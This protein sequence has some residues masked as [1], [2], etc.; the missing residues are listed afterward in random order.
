MNVDTE[1]QSQTRLHSLV[2]V[3]PATIAILAAIS[4]GASV[5]V[6]QLQ[7]V[8][9]PSPF[10]VAGSP[11]IAIWELDQAADYSFDDAKIEIASGRGQLKANPQW[12]DASYDYRVPLTVTAGAGGASVGQ[13]VSITA[14]TN[15]YVSLGIL[16]ADRDD[17]RIV[18]WNGAANIELDRDYVSISELRFRLQGAIAPNATSAAYFMYLGNASAVNPPANRE[19]VYE[20]FEDFS[21]DVFGAGTWTTSTSPASCTTAFSVVSNRLQKGN[22]TPGDCFAWDDNAT[23]TATDDWFVE[24]ELVPVSGVRPVVGSL[25]LHDDAGTGGYWAGLTENATDSVFIRNSAGTFTPTAGAT[26]NLGTTYRVTWLYDYA[27]A[28]SRT[29]TVWVDGTQV[30]QANDTSANFSLGTGKFGVHNYNPFDG[31][32][33]PGVIAWD[34]YK[35][36]RQVASV[37]AGN[38]EGRYAKT[39]TIE[40]ARGLRYGTLSS[41]SMRSNSTVTVFF[42]LSNDD[43]ATWRYSPDGVTW[44]PSD[45]S[46]AQ[47]NP[48]GLVNVAIGALPANG[49]LRWRAVFTTDDQGKTQHWLDQVAVGFTADPADE[50]GDGYMSVAAG[51]NDCTDAQTS[52]YVTGTVACDAAAPATLVNPQRPTGGRVPIADHAWVRDDNGLFHLFFQDDEPNNWS[53]LHYTTPD[54]STL[55]YIGKAVSATAGAWDANGAWAPHI[56]Q[57]DG[58][59]YMYYTGVRV[60]GY[61]EQ[62]IGLATSTDLTTWTK[63]AM[64]AC[65]GMTGDGC[66]SDCTAAW[67]A[68]GRGGGNDQAC[69]DPMVQFDPVSGTWKMFTT[70]R[71]VSDDLQGVSVASSSNLLNWSAEGYIGTTHQAVAENPFVTQFD[72]K[73][74]L[75]FT[76]YFSNWIQYVTSSTLVADASGSANW[77]AATSIGVPRYNAPEVQVI[78]NDTWLMSISGYADGLPVKMQRMVWNP[79]GTFALSNLTKLACRV[80]SDTIHPDATEVCGDMLDNDCNGQGDDPFLCAACVDA[81]GDGY[82]AVAANACTFPQA[83]CDDARSNVSPG[84]AEVCDGQDNDCDAQVD[85]GLSCEQPD[86]ACVPNWSCGAWSVCSHRQQTRTCT[87]A[88][89][90]GVT[91]SRP[92]LT[93]ACLMPDDAC[94]ENWSCT[95]WSACANGQQTR[96]CTDRNTC[97]TVRTQPLELQPCAVGGPTEDPFIAVTPNAGRPPVVRLFAPNGRRFAQWQAYAQ[98]L[99]RSGGATIAVGDVTGDGTS[100]IV[101][102]TPA[103]RRPLLRLF[104][105]AGQPLHEFH[106]YG[107]RSRVGVVVAS[108][109]LDGDGRDEVLTAPAGRAAPIVRLYRY[110]PAR[111]WFHHESSARIAGASTQGLSLAAAD[112][113]GDGADELIVGT[114]ARTTSRVRIYDYDARAKRFSLKQSFLAFGSN[115][116]LGVVVAA[117]DVDGDGAPEIVASSGPGG[118]PHVRV[119]G[120]TGNLEGQFMAASTRFRDGAYPAV[121]DLEGD[122]QA[123]ILTVSNRRGAPNVFIFTR[124][125]GGGFKRIGRFP[126]FPANYQTGLRIST[127]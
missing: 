39:A 112:V 115:H 82:G 99:R 36:W 105:Q 29:H 93:Q 104:S 49:T 74:Y 57:K 30:L 4:I 110:D 123:E 14:S 73:Y 7:V 117:G 107:V 67:T 12:W 35:A 10:V 28:A 63:V 56:I 92:A 71:L 86:E 118:A 96:T 15:P 94:L 3:F 124:Q 79:D 33:T 108:G 64:N 41:F 21:T 20:Y 77:S 97:G 95:E 125:S 54:F 88:A 122:G 11:Q 60:V 87:D 52:V 68:A 53:I 32:S 80:G 81:D 111:P 113:D 126:A 22:Y 1:V 50:D 76:N 9:P 61:P 114:L 116:R 75:F 23:L 69:R 58:M 55:T 19:A 16:Q 70:V 6:S 103:G 38:L 66:V 47:S 106:P 101:T 127:P 37:A 78:D 100:E 34:N 13:T 85:D 59:Y 98:E 42:Q 26:V 72:G 31:S 89:A 121:L 83:D 8:V 102:G 62:R 24:A 18:Y 109:D 5:Y 91:T 65:S 17:L 90:C 43:G 27:S 2:R 119:F 25:S 46:L 44:V 120:P 51:G 84:A 48:V 40:S 45:G